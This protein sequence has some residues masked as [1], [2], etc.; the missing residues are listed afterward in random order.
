VEK[1]TQKAAKYVPGS[2]L[3]IPGDR[4]W[5]PFRFNEKRGQWQSVEETGDGLRIYIWDNQYSGVAPEKDGESRYVEIED[6]KPMADVPQIDDET[7][8]Y[9]VILVKPVPRSEI[10]KSNKQQK[11]EAK[12]AKQNGGVLPTLTVANAV[13]EVK[14][15][16][17]PKRKLTLHFTYNEV[18]KTWTYG[19]QRH[20]GKIELFTLVDPPAL[21][22]ISYKHLG[23]EVKMSPPVEVEVVREVESDSGSVLKFE[24]RVRT[25][26]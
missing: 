10:P 8:F 19:F 21:Q 7:R 5:M 18:S 11:R 3:P 16:D 2:D 4:F 20:D 12:L 17:A 23:N 22:R 14:K 6:R 24:V 9:Q 25:A 15:V 1:T 13:V 26:N